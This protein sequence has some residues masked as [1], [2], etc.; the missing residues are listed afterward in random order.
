MLL[1]LLFLVTKYYQQMTFPASRLFPY[2]N[3]FSGCPDLLVLLGRQS[4]NSYCYWCWKLKGARWGGLQWHNGHAV[5][6]DFVKIC[7][8]V[9]KLYTTHTHTHYG[10]L[11][12]Q[13]FDTR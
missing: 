13:N 1:F 9:Q 10:D 5:M 8:L 11:R 12:V 4:R 2:N 6:P 7:R 3:L